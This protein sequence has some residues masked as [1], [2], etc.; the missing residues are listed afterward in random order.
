MHPQVGEIGNNRKRPQSAICTLGELP[1]TYK[2]KAFG[3]KAKKLVTRYFLLFQGFTQ[4]SVAVMLMT[5]TY[6]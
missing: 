1:T 5:T 3:D 4:S 6:K 2:S